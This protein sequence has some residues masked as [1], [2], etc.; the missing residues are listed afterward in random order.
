MGAM[1]RTVHEGLASHPEHRFPVECPG[2]A[3]VRSA[4]HLGAMRK[5]VIGLGALLAAS[6]STATLSSSSPFLG[7]SARPVLEVQGQ[8]SPAVIFESGLG[9]DRS[10]WRAVRDSLAG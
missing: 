10:P 3:R 9:D 2:V 6:L 7:A 1:F 4:T 8:G 5:Q